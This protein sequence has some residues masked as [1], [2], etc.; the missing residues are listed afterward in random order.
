MGRLTWIGISLAG[1][2]LATFAVGAATGF[3]QPDQVRAW[4]VEL[5]ARPGGRLLIAGLVFA[6]LAGDLVLAVPATPVMIAAGHQLGPWLGGAVSAAGA[7]A[8]VVIGYGVCRVGGRP[9]FGRW[10]KPDEAAR[11]R[12]MFDRYGLLAVVLARGLPILPEVMACMGGLVR[13]PA[14]R[15][16]GAF[17]IA[18]VP[19]ALLHALAGHYSSFANPWPALLVL[20]GLPVAA[21]TVA[22]R[23][24]RRTRHMR[25]GR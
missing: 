15:L 2:F 24:M 19:W 18:T 23:L 20:V 10:V 25:A 8:A 14:G 16:L 5:S 4:I 12:A 7:M 22:R 9:A 1:V 11:A 21:W 17:A 6:L 13:L 3:L